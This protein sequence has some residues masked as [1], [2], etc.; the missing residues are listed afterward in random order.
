MEYIYYHCG[1]H[2]TNNSEVYDYCTDNLE[3]IERIIKC[4][5]LTIF[6]CCCCYNH[7][8]VDEAYKYFKQY[9]K[10]NVSI[11][12][13]SKPDRFGSGSVYNYSYFNDHNR[14]YIYIDKLT[15]EVMIANSDPTLI[16]S[17]EEFLSAINTGTIIDLKRLSTSDFLFT[18]P[19]K[20]EEIEESLNYINNLLISTNFFLKSFN[21][22]THCTFATENKYVIRKYSCIK[23]AI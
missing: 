21:Q 7:T 6:D 1:D 3:I 11:N 15:N 12:F 4:N 5:Y 14:F 19:E 18:P 9:S 17:N 16:I 8:N 23:K 13:K 22:K 2:P 10:L 20:K